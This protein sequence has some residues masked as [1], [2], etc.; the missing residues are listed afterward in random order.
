MLCP[1]KTI[2]VHEKLA[3]GPTVVLDTDDC[4]EASECTFWRC[5]FSGI[6]Y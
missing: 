1:P 6:Q 2:T 5:L 4:P 3:I